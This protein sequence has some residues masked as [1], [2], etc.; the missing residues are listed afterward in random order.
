MQAFPALPSVS[1]WEQPASAVDDGLIA[2]GRRSASSACP[3]SASPR[4]ITPL[5]SARSPR[6]TFPSVPST[7]TRCVHALLPS[8]PARHPLP[9]PCTISRSP[10]AAASHRGCVFRSRPAMT[11][12]TSSSTLHLP[13]PDA[14]VCS[15]REVRLARRQVQAQV[16][17]SAGQL[18]SNTL[19]PLPSM[20]CRCN[21]SPSTKKPRCQKTI[22]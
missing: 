12:A 5:P 13:C 8:T 20:Q 14:R 10:K 4:F 17:G 16:R 21:L 15:R 11:H 2:C 7:P 9:S 22:T 6:K 19:A 3:T 1:P 18:P